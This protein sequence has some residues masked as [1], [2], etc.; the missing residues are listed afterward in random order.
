[1]RGEHTYRPSP[2]DFLRG[3]SPH[4]RRAPPSIAAMSCAKGIIPAC[5]G[6][7]LS[8]QNGGS[9]VGDHPR[10]RGEHRHTAA[11]PTSAAG[12]SP[13]ARGAP[14]CG[15][16]SHLQAGIIPACAG[17]TKRS[18]ALVIVVG[19]HPRMRGE[20]VLHNRLD[21]CGQGSS[22]HA[23]GAQTAHLPACNLGGIIPACAGSTHRWN[24]A[25]GAVRDHPRMRGEHAVSRMPSTT[26]LGSSPHARGA[27]LRL[28]RVNRGRGIIPACAGSTMGRKPALCVSG[29]HPRMRGEHK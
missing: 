16:S 5:A 28:Y 3:S 4:A 15:A 1:M 9:F 13:H 14:S 27:R 11:M 24:F 8:T 22:P 17:S 23:R 2:I 21:R 10:M 18:F 20:H 12:S 19:D 26:A 25:V 6:S 7:T 29:D